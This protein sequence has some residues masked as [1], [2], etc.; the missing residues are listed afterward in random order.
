MVGKEP[1]SGVWAN[2]HR[3][4]LILQDSYLWRVGRDGR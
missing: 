1:K 3:A 4:I 2:G